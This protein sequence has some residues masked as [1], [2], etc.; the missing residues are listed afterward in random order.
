MGLYMISFDFVGSLPL[1]YIAEAS[2]VALAI[3]IGGGLL[4]LFCILVGLT[5]PS[6]R[7][8]SV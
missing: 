1:S 8:L 5:L 2:G 7:R 4:V 3:G 6:F